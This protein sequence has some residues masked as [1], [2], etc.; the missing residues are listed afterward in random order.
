M[1]YGEN[2]QFHAISIV[3]ARVSAVGCCQLETFTGFEAELSAHVSAACARVDHTF[4]GRLC[5][6][7]VCA[8]NYS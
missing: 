7:F 3:I 4:S 6:G 8:M 2:L 5:N 1:G